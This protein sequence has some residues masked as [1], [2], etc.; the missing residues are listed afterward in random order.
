MRF[1]AALAVFIFSLPAQ[2]TTGALTGY[3]LDPAGRAIAT[4]EVAVQSPGGERRAPVDA[5]GRYRLE[6]LR[7]GV[8]RLTATAPQFREGVLEQIVVSVNTVAR[9]DLRLALAGESQTVTVSTSALGTESAE[10]GAVIPQRQLA[11]LPLNRRDFL[12]LA[13][14]LPGVAPPV[15]GS[16]LSQKGGFSM[17]VNGAREE[18]NNFLL[19]GVDNNDPN[20]NRYSLQPP[21]D[22]IEEF[23]IATN[24]Y[25]AEYARSAGG[26]V[27][28]ITR[29]G[30]NELHG[31]AYDY[32]R[33]RHLDA[34]NF[35]S[36]AT[37]PHFVRH[38]FGGGLGGPLRANR[39]FFFANW[40]G[41]R[42]RRGIPRLGTVPGEP[43]RRG[44]L[45]S[46]S[47]TPLDPFTR[48]P[49]PGKQIP[50][51]RIHPV[52]RPVLALFPL[53]NRG[54][55][56]GNLLSQPILDGDQRQWNTR[57]DH[58]LSTRGQL[59]LR[60]SQGAADIFEPFA[61]DITNVPGFGDTVRDR[62]H[63]ALAQHTYTVSPR[64]LNAFTFGI[65]RVERRVL[66][67]NID[68]DVNRLW[69]VT[70]LPA[71]PISFGYP[72][73]NIA[74][75]SSLGDATAFPIDRTASTYQFTNTVSLTLGRHVWKF[76]AE[77]RR[78]SHQGIN[79]LLTRGSLTFSGAVSGTG[80][81]DALLGL[82]A[83][84]I[85]AQADNAQSLR[86]T[87]WNFFAQD[88]W[89]LSRRLTLSLGLRYEYNT[90]ATDPNDRM[91]LLSL[92]TGRLTRAGAEGATRSGY[93]PDR[94]NLAP[95]VGLAWQLDPK[96][97]I[98]T[99]YGVYFD[100]GLLVANTALYFNPPYFTLR[101]HFPTATS[102][103]TLNDPFPARGGIAPP[104]SL[105]TLSPDLRNSYLQ[106]WNFNIQRSAGAGVASLAYAGTK[107][108][109]LLRSRDFNQPTP[110]AGD[111]GPRRPLPAFANIFLAESGGNSTYHSLQA[112]YQRPLARR[113]SLLAAYTWA[114]S[115]D[116][117]SAFLGTRTDKNFPQNS[118]AFS[119]ERGLS[120]FHQSQ[121]VSA[122]SVW[123]LPRGVQASLI[124]TAAAGQPLT[125]IL[126]FDNSNTGNTGGQFGSDRPDA[127]RGSALSDPT[128][129]RWF[130]TAA[131]VLPPR[132]R[133]GNSG[134]NTVTGPGFATVD[135][136]LAKRFALTER[137]ALHLEAQA[138][139]LLNRTNFDMP[140]RFAD[141]PSTFGRI[142]SAKSPRQGQLVARFVF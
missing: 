34:R 15:E 94:N 114:K 118:Q 20:I 21:V 36:D 101:V 70:W 112:S 142:F 38:Q 110:A 19:D 82:P 128:S 126:R 69:G 51:S 47:G 13:L 85:Q 111:I 129:S 139:N 2:V 77:L 106:Q 76:G 96:T 37:K 45:S 60:Y 35:F 83:L 134:R 7:S 131:F 1:F 63:N 104:A 32:F 141:E 107:G 84:G 11:G 74:G 124:A 29:S 93:R 52:A 8:Y 18:Y 86:S 25:S 3:V 109:A 115:I 135:L 65:N 42:E 56:A 71:K 91:S 33:H 55:G 31:F 22:A 75:Y 64:L 119:L 50:A 92:S 122:A 80:L 14:L 140:D 49:F 40:D 4:A 105:S 121:R 26:Q 123:Q 62:G 48:Q 87:A 132:F 102:L 57:L 16:Q 66:P 61:Q 30:G 17:H 95:R 90:P 72:A 28:V 100:S 130:D 43:E 125:P 89:R 53:P 103:L 6:G 133:F 39:T 54:L 24:S 67:E 97:V 12:Q 27:N 78:I 116:D 58:R 59:T 136:A 88:D 117:T 10:L 23:K 98:R 99:G 41:Y 73:M 108:T 5:E 79:D 68:K 81:S 44:D 9:A 137:L 138:F 46:L 120:S 113:W 127:V